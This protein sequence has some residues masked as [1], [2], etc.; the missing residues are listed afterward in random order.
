VIA[1]KLIASSNQSAC[2][3]GPLKRR[4]DPSQVGC[5]SLPAPSDFANLP[6]ISRHLCPSLAVKDSN[7]RTTH[8]ESLFSSNSSLIMNT[9]RHLLLSCCF[10]TRATAITD[11][12]TIPQVDP[13]NPDSKKVSSTETAPKDTVFTPSDPSAPVTGTQVANNPSTSA[14]TSQTPMVSLT[15]EPTINTPDALVPTPPTSPMFIFSGGAA[16]PSPRSRDFPIPSIELTDTLPGRSLDEAMT[17]SLQGPAPHFGTIDAPNDINRSPPEHDTDIFRFGESRE[18]SPFTFHK[19]HKATPEPSQSADHFT[20]KSEAGVGLLD[21]SEIQRT[22]KTLA[23]SNIKDTSI[24]MSDYLGDRIRCQG[25]APH[26]K[27]SCM[28]DTM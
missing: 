18:A 4:E 16:K 22:A 27:E 8:I 25:R 12:S 17:K 7:I 15:T 23:S 13:T 10:Q 24:L 14:S 1:D 19:M 3:S 28:A 20:D 5:A 2:S 21:D 26:G 9:L 6:L 11:N